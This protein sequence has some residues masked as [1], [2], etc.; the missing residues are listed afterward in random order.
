MGIIF[1]GVVSEVAQPKEKDPPEYSD[2]TGTFQIAPAS[3]WDNSK[4]PRK[5][6]LKGGG[7]PDSPPA[8][9]TPSV[10]FSHVDT[11]E[12]P[13]YEEMIQV[14]EP[15]SSPKATPVA[16]PRPKLKGGFV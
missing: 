1:Y 11:I 13:P 8:T 14:S 9:H 5:S 10:Q 7:Q 12:S 15:K 4:L 6:A 2:P 3:D 16:A